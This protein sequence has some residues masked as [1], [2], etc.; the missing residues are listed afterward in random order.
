MKIEDHKAADEALF[1]LFARALYAHGFVLGYEGAPPKTSGEEGLAA[2][3]FKRE[4][5]FSRWVRYING[6]AGREGSFTV[7]LYASDTDRASR[8]RASAAL[9]A[10][11]DLAASGAWSDDEG[12][13]DIF[14]LIPDSAPSR[15]RY[16]GDSCIWE[17]RFLYRLHP[18]LKGRSAC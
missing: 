12:C 7:R 5:A 18:Y 2:A 6:K 17:M 3:V 4:S 1:A 11:A 13:A 9:W 8:Q 16:E 14:M 10:L 15:I